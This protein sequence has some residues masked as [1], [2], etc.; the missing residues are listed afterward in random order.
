MIA[1]SISSSEL[2]MWI[3][4][5]LPQFAGFKIQIY[6]SSDDNK[7]LFFYKVDKLEGSNFLKE[8]Y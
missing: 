6:Y 7:L 8:F 5:P 1:C 2:T 3:P 4:S